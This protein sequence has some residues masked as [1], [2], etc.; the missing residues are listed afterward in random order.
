VTARLAS[1]LD[2]EQDRIVEAWA[3]ALS[4]MR[5]SIYAHRPLEELRRLGRSYLPCL[6]A[7]LDTGDPSRLREFIQQEAALRLGMGFGAAEVVQGFLTFRELVGQIC[8]ELVPDSAD[9]VGLVGSLSDAIDHTVLE[10]VSHYQHLVDEREA[11]Q[12]REVQHLRQVLEERAVQ[13]PVT[14][15]YIAPL[16]EEHLG[17]EIRRAAR[18]RRALSM[19]ICDLDGYGAFR[20][21]FGERAAEEALRAVAGVLREQTR[22]VDLK[23]RTDEAEFAVALPD[24]PLISA[25]VAA[26]RLRSTV[27]ELGIRPS[28]GGGWTRGDLTAS[29]GVGASPEHGS[30]AQELLAS[31]RTARDRARLLGGNTVV[32]ALAGQ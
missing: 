13:D 17:V 1:L 14:E 18:Y 24:T 16:F 5:P 31:V 29:V 28:V 26:E 15:L 19:L 4:T 22:E 27:A 10:F 6:V 25:V 3:S 20:S 11:A 21:R 32:W 2:R 8:G 30:T 7:Y 9:Q 12:V 23:G